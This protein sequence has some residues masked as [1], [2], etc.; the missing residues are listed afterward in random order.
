MVA[1]SYTWTNLP[2]R[3]FIVILLIVAILSPSTALAKPK[4]DLK[5]K[6][7]YNLELNKDLKLRVIKIPTEFGMIE[8]DGNGTTANP[9]KGS[10][11]VTETV[12]DLHII[13][14]DNTT[15]VIP[16]GTKFYA[17][18]L[19]VNHE[20]KYQKD[21]SVE[22][23]FFKFEVPG[24]AEVYLRDKSLSASTKKE[25]SSLA[26]ALSVGAYSLAGMVVAPLAT[27]LGLGLSGNIVS[28]GAGASPY[29]YGAAAV[30]GG[31]LGLAYGITHK[32]VMRKVEPG[33]EIKV[34]P[35]DKWQLSMSESLPSL[36]ELTKA[37]AELEQQKSK[38]ANDC[39]PGAN[40]PQDPALLPV[41]I[42]IVKIKRSTD[43][44][45]SPSIRVSFNFKNNTK[46]KLRYSSFVMVD[47]MGRE[48]EASPSTIEEDSIGEIP[49]SGLFTMNFPVEFLKS[50]HYLQVR[51]SHKQRVLASVKVVLKN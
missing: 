45:G 20:Q 9:K 40:C 51:S 50:V 24:S 7:E 21:G 39:S 23:E 6:V 2:F 3:G 1:S 15:R 34:K 27:A 30:L 14:A 29:I 36:E 22:M 18:I 25:K 44:Y 4:P 46:E 37:R 19:G 11:I 48:F 33:T 41:V 8:L 26:K 12:E 35:S 38:I 42:D 43:I 49:E 31:G 16:A 47:S 13:A 10:V 5:A 28:L 17:R 32:G